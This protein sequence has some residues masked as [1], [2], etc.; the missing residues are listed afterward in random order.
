MISMRSIHAAGGLVHLILFL[1]GEL[2][3]SAR[4]T[5][6]WG[7]LS[8]DHCQGDI[9][10]IKSP[11]THLEPLGLGNKQ[12][13]LED[14]TLILGEPEKEWRYRQMFSSAGIERIQ[15]TICLSNWVE[16]I[17]I[18]HNDEVDSM[19]KDLLMQTH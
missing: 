8:G 1:G 12:A 3:D 7:N 15:K 19:G 18:D 16:E 13:Q 2:Q 11:P 10:T 5:S 4:I 9:S 14:D 6:W 17:A